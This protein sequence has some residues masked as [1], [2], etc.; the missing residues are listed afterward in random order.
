MFP[1]L[2]TTAAITTS[3]PVIAKERKAIN[4]RNIMKIPNAQSLRI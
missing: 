3:Q 1:A 4:D 2:S